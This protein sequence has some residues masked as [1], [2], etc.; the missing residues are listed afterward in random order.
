MQLVSKI[1]SLCGHDPLTS[2]MERQMDRQMTRN[3]KTALC[4][5]ASHDKNCKAILMQVGYFYVLLITYWS[6]G[7]VC[8][9]MTVTFYFKCYWLNMYSVVHTALLLT[10][11]AYFCLM[12][13]WL[14]PS[15][16]WCCWLGC[17]KSIWPAKNWV[18]GCWCGYLSGVR[19]K[20]AYGPADAT[21]IHYLLLQ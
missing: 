15:V 2:Q 18:V 21:A 4:T 19:C 16:L 3:R 7:T 5:S 13:F 14:M 11:M 9:P 10:V 1:F 20:F 12:T 8:W 6:T 17:R